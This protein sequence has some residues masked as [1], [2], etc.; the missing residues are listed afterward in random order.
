MG[1][2]LK[3]PLYEVISM[4]GFDYNLFIRDEKEI[5]KP[6]LEEKGY[7]DIQFFMGEQ[8]SFGP[9][10]RICYCKDPDGNIKAFIYG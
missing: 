5:L 3:Q 10:S 4:D 8:D 6:R 9:L 1:V 2:T 7:T